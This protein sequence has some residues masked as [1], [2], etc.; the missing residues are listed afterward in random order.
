MPNQQALWPLVQCLAVLAPL[1]AGVLTGLALH[2]KTVGGVFRAVLALTL[3]SSA[4]GLLTL[5]RPEV[6][7]FALFQLVFWLPAGCL[8]AAVTAALRRQL[9]L[10]NFRHTTR[11]S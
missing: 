6:W 1:L 4:A 5:P 2:P 9:R 7:Q 3:A 11:R 8:S 10:Q